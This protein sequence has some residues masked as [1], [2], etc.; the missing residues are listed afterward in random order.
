[1]EQFQLSLAVVI[2]IQDYG[3][4][5]SPLRTATADAEAVGQLLEQAHGYTVLMLL[6]TDATRA[7]LVHLFKEEL[8]KRFEGMAPNRSRLLVYYAGHGVVLRAQTG[9]DGFLLPQDAQ[10]TREESFL[11]MRS[12]YRWLSELPCHHLLVVLDCCFAATFRWAN[13]REAVLADEVMYEA[14]YEYFLRNR[15]AQVLTSAAHDEKALDVVGAGYALGRREREGQSH[16][17]FAQ[18]LLEGLR[19]EADR[20]PSGAVEGDGLITATEL[21]VYLQER[22]LQG[23][24][25][26]QVRQ[27]P[28]LSH[29]EHH[30]GGEFL[31]RVPGRPLTL[32]STPALSARTNPYRGLGAFEVDDADLFFG[33]ERLTRVLTERVHEAALTGVVG[34]SGTGK[35][36]L[37]MAGLLPALAAMRPPAP[38]WDVLGPLRPENDIGAALTRASRE[39]LGQAA[40]TPSLS[41]AVATWLGRHPEEGARLLVVVDQWEELFTRERNAGRRARFLTD[42]RE[43]AEHPSGRVR[44]VGTLRL[45][46]EWR[47][48]AELGEQWNAARMLL[49][50]ME[51]D[52]L[53]AAIV[54]PASARALFFE[55]P[56]LVERLLDDMASMPG[57]LPLLSFTLGELY[58]ACLKAGDRKLRESDYVE[59]GGVR[60][61]LWKRAERV[62]DELAPAHQDSMRRLLLRLSATEAGEAARRRVPMRELRFEVT[63]Q[64]EQDEDARVESV[65]AQLVNARL[66]VSDGSS[67]EPA[68]D[69]LLGWTRLLEWRDEARPENL[70]LQHRV[71]Q[72]ATDWEARGRADALLWGEDGRLPLAEQLR[73]TDP[74]WFNALETEFLA[75]STR[76]RLARER[77]NRI[78]TTSVITV[79]SVAVVVLL[80]LRWVAEERREEALARTLAARAESMVMLPGAR[81]LVVSTLLGIES[82]RRHPTPE[83]DQV[84]RRSLEM[85]PPPAAWSERFGP[86][87]DVAFSLDS[88]RVAVVTRDGMAV[89][90]DPLTG[91]R[92]STLTDRALAV[93]VGP[94][95]GTLAVAVGTHVFF[96]PKWD[97]ATTALARGVSLGSSVERLRFSPR[98]TWLVLSYGAREELRERR[99]GAP[100]SWLPEG[101]FSR[102]VVGPDERFLATL[103]ENNQ[104]QLWDTAR[105]RRILPPASR[106]SGGLGPEAEVPLLGPV[107]FS[108]DGKL[109]AVMEP[110]ALG[111]HELDPWRTR[112]RVVR[113]EREQFDESI[114]VLAFSEDSETLALGTAMGSVRL[115]DLEGRGQERSLIEPM[116]LSMLQPIKALAFHPS[117]GELLV[118][119]S[120][121]NALGGPDSVADVGL[122]RL[123]EPGSPLGNRDEEIRFLETGLEQLADVRFSPTG[124]LGVTRGRQGIKVW[125]LA[126]HGASLVWHPPPG[127]S[128]L[129]QPQV[130]WSP[131][132]RWLASTLTRERIDVFQARS[133]TPVSALPLRSATDKK[134]PVF[135]VHALCFDRDEG[136]LV[137]LLNRNS[138]RRWETETWKELKPVDLSGPAQVLESAFS[139]NCRWAVVVQSGTLRVHD[140]KTS[141]KASELPRRARSGFLVEIHA[142]GISNDGERVVVFYKD[143]WFELHSRSS[144]APPV[145]LPPIDTSREYF[146][147]AL[148]PDG[149]VLVSATDFGDLWL[150]DGA[151]GR[152]SPQGA[153]HFETLLE[154]LRFMPDG[155]RFAA[156]GALGRATIW[157]VD[158]SLA[159]SLS[160]GDSSIWDVAFS[161]DGHWLATAR[162]DSVQVYPLHSVD[163]IKAACARLRRN[164]S[165]AEWADLVRDDEYRPTC[166]WKH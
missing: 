90:V 57:A 137:A 82:L 14:R 117:G 24:F 2:G 16:S 53:R 165:P 86:L 27:T 144:K 59:L 134:P 95:T 33:R 48:V 73:R 110:G 161:P 94:V 49:A 147:M 80:V 44:V 84:V 46:S 17:P 72:A 108:P 141:Q 128:H 130:A 23:A 109:L 160:G 156:A 77:R 66:L 88:R 121:E 143:G 45:D 115:F 38:R 12:V 123:M 65:V 37:V 97:G 62:H 6:D 164:L 74:Y 64:G 131:D 20:P 61:A 91:T 87:R 163:L 30:E 56:T 76:L 29:F 18:A 35:S 93:D 107:A 122:W 152:H 148:S 157:N 146:Q 25:G 81:R 142:V 32:T 129:S 154:A 15:A 11:P 19:A 36:S 83:G 124:A 166:E 105:R 4:G 153:L 89:V 113:S 9:P 34:R 151:T 155:T 54:R 8:P 126:E 21:Y 92:V 28:G 125:N 98:E 120:R 69:A 149:K 75:R 52:E 71:R 55:P 7:R 119:S 26:E 162:D 51:R 63:G 112:R 159:L 13:R 47:L 138:V 5:V 133:G 136:T 3:N 68:H 99:T 1:M 132:G 140:L 139:E 118:A 43:A 70:L 101:P 127:D 96:W 50:P 10:A 41:A 145:L 78:L 158:G 100:V 58:G 104:V 135:A 114:N 85:N 31:F 102:I 103:D 116:R 40:A 106:A 60:K 67:V 79:F 22:R 42:L 150:L 39:L 111:I